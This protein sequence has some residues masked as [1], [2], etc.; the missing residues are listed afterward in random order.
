MQAKTLLAGV[1]PRDVAGATR[2][3]IAAEYLTE[4]FTLDAKLKTIKVELP[5]AV[6]TRGSQLMGL[7][8]IGAAGAARILADVGDVT[9]FPSKAHFAAWNGTA[10]LDASSGQQLRHRLSRAGNRRI[11]HVL[12]VMAIVQIRHDT[13]ERVYYR[14]RLTEGKTPMEALR[15]LKGACPTSSTSNCPPTAPIGPTGPPRRAR[16][17]TRGRLLAPARPASTPTPAL[18][19]S[20]FP[21]PPDQRLQP[22]QPGVRSVLRAVPDGA[23]WRR[24]QPV[25]SALQ[26]DTGEDRR[27]LTGPGTP[28]P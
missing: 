24:P 25:S 4:L 22:P 17:D 28:T 11:N 7:F 1:R 26:L 10:P 18:R 14:R 16:E 8:G 12:H 2:R 20:H 27:T 13:A 6:T 23:P 9:R 5:D 15:C 21:D 3:R 19:R